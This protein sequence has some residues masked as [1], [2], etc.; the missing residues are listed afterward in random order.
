MSDDNIQLVGKVVKSCNSI[1]KVELESGQIVTCTPSGKIRKNN[2]KIMEGDSVNIEVS[3][4]D[5]TK[6]R[7]VKR[8]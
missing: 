2:I 7:I 1:F 3:A 8:N 5:L 4:Y 6:G